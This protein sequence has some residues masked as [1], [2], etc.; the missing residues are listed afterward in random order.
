M[1]FQLAVA[2]LMAAAPLSN[3]FVTPNKARSMLIGTQQPARHSRTFLPSSNVVEAPKA[4]TNA[5]SDGVVEPL[6]GTWECNDEAECVQVPECTD[7]ECR[8][9]LDVRI[10]GQWYDL[11]GAL[12]IN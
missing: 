2:A 4:P 5:T 9:S 12:Q 11:T 7:E 3:A 10:H 6:A 8:T 1:K